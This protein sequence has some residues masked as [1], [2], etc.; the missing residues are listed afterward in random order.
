MSESNA[1]TPQAW[2][3]KTITLKARPRGCHLITSEVLNNL[4]ELRNYNVGLCNIFIQHTSASL[5]I[6]ENASPDVPI[7]MESSL[8]RIVPEDPKLYTHLDEGLD[9]MPAHVKTSLM[10][11]SLMIPITRGRLAL[12]TWQ[13]IWLNEHRDHGGSRRIVVTIQGA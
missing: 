1:G 12:G 10:G 6:N 4:P 8:N 3:Q 5:T 9:D 7:D 13:G 2:F 11:F